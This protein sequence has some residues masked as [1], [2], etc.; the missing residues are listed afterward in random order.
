MLKVTVGNR[1]VNKEGTLTVS[2]DVSKDDINLFAELPE[3]EEI[4]TVEAE[5]ANNS[6]EIVAALR[7]YHSLAV[8]HGFADLLVVCEP[9][10]D[11]NRKLLK[12]AKEEG[13]RTALVSGQAVNRMG[14]VE[15][16]DTGKSDH[17]DPKVINTLTKL[18]KTFED[19]HLD[20]N[21]RRLRLLNEM[22]EEEEKAMVTAKNLVHHVFNLL[23][24]DWSL[25]MDLVYGRLGTG[26]W[27]VYR[28]DPIDI[29]SGG[30]AKFHAVAKKYS[31]RTRRDTLRKIWEAAAS[32]VQCAPPES[33]REL[34]KRRLEQLLDRIREHESNKEAFKE[35]MT[36]IYA[37]L[38]EGREF[39]DFDV[40]SKF[41]MARLIAETGPLKD[42]SSYRE[43]YRYV[44]LNLR[45]RESGKFAGKIKITKRGRSLFRKVMFQ[46]AFSL[47][48]RKRGL[49]HDLHQKKKSD[50]GGCG[51]KALV[52][53][54]RFLTKAIWGVCRSK[55]KF[56][57]SRL[58]LC[59]SALNANRA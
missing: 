55:T 24:S 22:Y 21:Y 2:A 50:L 17:K 1:K 26:L 53:L 5:I 6:R 49:F 15:S 44:G 29:V 27:K 30:R 42:F 10:G 7:E 13:H 35:D 19:R 3:Q 18:N 32:G 54:M 43:L 16:N 47:V 48:G 51:T 37:S 58:F 34:L 11:Y 31:P 40:I 45:E 4:K 25:K 23:F 20:E 28:F 41:H 9:T 12:I 38:D 14:V 36:S 57:T 46:V 52:R 33:E 8:E 39:K 56:D 59:E